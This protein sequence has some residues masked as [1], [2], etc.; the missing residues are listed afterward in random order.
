MPQQ[1]STRGLPHPRTLSSNSDTLHNRSRADQSRKLAD[2]QSSRGTLS[3]PTNR[4]KLR[5]R[6]ADLECHL[7]QV[8]EELKTLKDQLPLKRASKKVEKK[9][10]KHQMV[11]ESLE[12][13]ENDSISVQIEEFN[14]KY[15]TSACETSYE[16]Q[17]GTD[18]FEVPAE[19]VT[20]KL[21]SKL[22][23]QMIEMKLNQNLL[24]YQLNHQTC[25]SQKSHHYMS[26]L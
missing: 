11:L 18:V 17:Q 21:T 14:D 16:N 2:G 19:K 12:T 7:G 10:K 25:R 23:L 20:M 3:D 4:K 13:R 24:F 15:N 9:S 1:Q 26:W 5:T 8:H 6:I 22:C